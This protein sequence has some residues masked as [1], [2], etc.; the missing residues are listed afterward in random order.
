MLSFQ[1]LFISPK[2]Q[3][4]IK[5]MYMYEYDK[6]ALEKGKEVPIKQ[7][8]HCQDALRYLIMGIWKY[9][10]RILPFVKEG[11]EDDYE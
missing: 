4:L 7:N 8:D 2:Q 5:E 9:I 1:R 6:D 3:H 11:D 10:R